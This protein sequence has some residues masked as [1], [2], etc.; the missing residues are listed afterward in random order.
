MKTEYLEEL[1]IQDTL[2][3]AIAIAPLLPL[4]IHQGMHG[5]NINII[6]MSIENSFA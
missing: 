2:K 5:V 3:S 1:I 6:I 4:F